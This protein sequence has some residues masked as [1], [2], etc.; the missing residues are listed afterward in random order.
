MDPSFRNIQQEPD[1][2]KLLEKMQEIN[3]NPEQFKRI[4]SNNRSNIQAALKALQDPTTA[5]EKI[6]EHFYN[7]NATLDKIL[8]KGNEGRPKKSSSIR[9]KILKAWENT[10]DHRIRSNMLAKEARNLEAALHVKHG[11]EYKPSAFYS[12]K[13]AHLAKSGEGS[14]QLAELFRKK[15]AG[16][17]SSEWKF[18]RELA[19]QYKGS[20]KEK[21]TIID[22][23]RTKGH[24][25]DA[26][27]AAFVLIRTAAKN[28]HPKAQK[29]LGDFYRSKG[30]LKRAE[31][32]YTKAAPNN[33]EAEKA[34]GEVKTAIQEAAAEHADYIINIFD[35][36]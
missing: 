11:M 14:Y 12:F 19:A 18:V 24:L 30:Q 28:G 4:H 20:K 16:V 27:V 3:K 26:A 22:Y 35:T 5:Q 1:Y 34:L 6:K 10:F 15:G 31:S 23:M 32:W 29:E 33:P 2:N 25:S 7:L 36:P 9:E 13:K 17:P 21:D 8:E